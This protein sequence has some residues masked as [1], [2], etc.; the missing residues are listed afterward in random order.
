MMGRLRHGVRTGRYTADFPDE[1][2]VFLIG[3]RINRLASV[4]Q[5]L[6]TFLAMPK[7][8][9]E[10]AERPEAGM[11]GARSYVSGRV[12][13][14]VQYWSSMDALLTYASD[15][16]SQHLPAWK[17]FNQRARAATG[18]VGIFHEA[19]TVSTGTAH[20]VYSGMPQFGMGLAT[21]SPPANLHRAARGDDPTGVRGTRGM[22]WAQ[23]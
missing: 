2:V 1:T 16:E 22:S 12:V 5:W 4:R 13:M 14:V 21:S 18:V 10:L 9:R 23:D 19:Y 15:R 3:M 8:L 11:L 7:M 20:T 17:A 6:P